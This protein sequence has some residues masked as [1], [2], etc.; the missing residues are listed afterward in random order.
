MKYKEWV[1]DFVQDFIDCFGR[2]PTQAEIAEAYE[3]AQCM[4]DDSE[5]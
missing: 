3:L 4:E 1:K 2:K 5:E